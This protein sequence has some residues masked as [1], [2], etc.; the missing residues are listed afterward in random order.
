MVR[1]LNNALVELAGAL[2]GFITGVSATLSMAASE[3]LCI[4]SSPYAGISFSVAALSFHRMGR[5]NMD[6]DRALRYE[7][8]EDPG[9]QILSIATCSRKD[10]STS[11]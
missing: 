2:A 6:G 11:K 1:G 8:T 9:W 3:Y 10:M 5:Q 4:F 7:S